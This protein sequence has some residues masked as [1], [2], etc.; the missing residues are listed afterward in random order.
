M[1]ALAN[2]GFKFG[3][4][5]DGDSMFQSVQ[6]PAGWTREGS[7][8]AMWSYVLDQHD[9]QRLSIFYKAAFYDRDAFFNITPAIQVSADDED[10]VD[11]KKMV[12]H[13][14]KCGKIVFSTKEVEAVGDVHSVYDVRD[15]ERNKAWAWATKNYPDHE[16]PCAYWD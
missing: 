2:I 16:D 14:K 1:E 9:R 11:G 6:L 12:F 13:V 4:L 15:S 3:E 5:V 10:T 8:H 7:N